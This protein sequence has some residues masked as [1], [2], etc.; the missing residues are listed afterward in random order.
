M[1]R[2]LCAG[3]CP[4]VSSSNLLPDFPSILNTAYSHKH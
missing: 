2:A 3:A 4:G 1:N